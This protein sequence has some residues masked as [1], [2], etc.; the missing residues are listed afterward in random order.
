[1]GLADGLGQV[2]W[3][4]PDAAGGWPPPWSRP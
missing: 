3:R 4:G 2:L 1:M